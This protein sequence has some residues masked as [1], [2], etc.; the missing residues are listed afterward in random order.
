VA[1]HYGQEQTI[2]Q[3]THFTET[4][5]SI[6]DLFLTSNSDINIQY[7]VFVNPSKINQ[8]HCPVFCSCNL[9][10]PFQQPYRRLILKFGRGYY[11]LLRIKVGNFDWSSLLDD[12]LD[13]YAT[14]STS[15]LLS[16]SKETIPFGHSLHGCI[17]TS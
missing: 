14:I 15:Q 7:V 16:C 3:P 8:F 4:S 11:E 10:K 5:S 9:S 2:S 1:S 17:K 6:I 13:T 12:S